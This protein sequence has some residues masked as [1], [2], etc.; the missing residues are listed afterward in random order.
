MLLSTCNCKKVSI[1]FCSIMSKLLPRVLDWPYTLSILPCCRYQKQTDLL[2][3][4]QPSIIM[5]LSFGIWRLRKRT[6]LEV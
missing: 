3:I 5:E 4:K 1:L 2:A 6:L